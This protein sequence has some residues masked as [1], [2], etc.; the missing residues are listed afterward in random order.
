ML[1]SR[2]SGALWR[3][4][5]R[6]TQSYS[7]AAAA[8]PEGASAASR[9][10]RV[11]AQRLKRAKVRAYKDAT[12]K[13]LTERVDKYLKTKFTPTKYK[14]SK[15]MKMLDQFVGIYPVKYD[16]DESKL[17]NAEFAKE[18]LFAE[19]RP[20]TPTNGLPASHIRYLSHAQR[21]L[22]PFTNAYTPFCSLRSPHPPKYGVSCL[23]SSPSSRQRST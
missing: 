19:V 22:L 21:T 3:T 8:T 2:L 14:K 12:Q 20:I 6:S 4:N 23:S 16:V 1:T 18:G 13:I 11:N 7:T 9:P 15:T 10:V 17:S 5:S